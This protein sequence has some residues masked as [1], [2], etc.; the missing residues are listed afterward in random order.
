MIEEGLSVYE[1][2]VLE[3]T[4]VK[5]EV[6][7]LKRK[8]LCANFETPLVE[9]I[10]GVPTDWKPIFI[11]IR[12]GFEMAMLQ[13]KELPTMDDLSIEGYH[14][15][16]LQEADSVIKKGGEFVEYLMNKKTEAK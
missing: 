11:K 15:C 12:K 14:Q 10:V 8:C 16:I 3:D 1:I 2:G 5:R 4:L 7:Y 13:C 6:Q 9:Y